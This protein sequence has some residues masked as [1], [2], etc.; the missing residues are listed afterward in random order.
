MEERVSYAVVGFFVLV[1]GLAL[2]AIVLWLSSG[3]LFQPPH[4]RYVA[5]MRESVSGLSVNA[6]VKYRGVD[7][8][9]VRDIDLNPANPEEVLLVLDIEEGT[10]IKTDTVAVL[11]MQGLTGIA[12]V[13]L[14]GG[15]REAPLLQA[16]P[17]ERYPEIETGP[18]LFVRLDTAVTSVLDS[19]N[20]VANDVGALLD[21]ENRRAFGQVMANLESIT[22][23]LAEHREALGQSL[24]SA[25]RAL[26]QGADATAELSELLVRVGT[27]A[28]AVEHM[29]REFAGVG[30]KLGS[31]IED[32][33][34]DMRRF[35]GQTLPEFG[36]LVHE[37]R[38]MTAT[39]QRVGQQLERDPSVLL[40]GRRPQEPGPGEF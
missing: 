3:L 18:S 2:V 34:R 29:A 19:L 12:F 35:T 17:G 13:D 4:D 36:L 10:P 37:L 20:R 38:E 14:T 25:S 40:R 15:S 21:E 23:A 9:R 24:E 6:P 5:Y 27:S 26:E 32:G 11:S 39:L 1:L 7:V 33:G 16:R 8:G 28:E 30:A 31:V 22:A